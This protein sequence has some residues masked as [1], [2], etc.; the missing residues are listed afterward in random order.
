MLEQI[1][2]RLYIAKGIFGGK[3]SLSL[4]FDGT[5]LGPRSFVFG[6]FKFQESQSA[7]DVVITCVFIG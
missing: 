1:I 7:D 6:G 5:A 2:R 3:V 4:S